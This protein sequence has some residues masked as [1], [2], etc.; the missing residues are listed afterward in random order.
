MESCFVGE[1]LLRRGADVMREYATWFDAKRLPPQMVDGEVVRAVP[2][3]AAPG[4]NVPQ[5]IEEGEVGDLF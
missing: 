4:R 5:P 3:L 2:Q 1:E